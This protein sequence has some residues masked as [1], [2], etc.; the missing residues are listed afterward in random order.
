MKKYRLM[1]VILLLVTFALILWQ[2][3]S[4]TRQVE[5]DN[6][7]RSLDQ[8]LSRYTLSLK[9]EL[10]KYQNLPALLATDRS[11][12]NVLYN[13]DNRV[14]VGTLNRYLS[15]VRTITGASDIYLMAPS[16]QTLASS[17]WDTP[18]SFVG[19]NFHYRP[20]FQQ[21]MAGDEGR[22][23]ALGTTSRKRG[24]YFS[25]PIRSADAVVG[26]VVVKID[27]NDIEEQW[28][29]ELTDLL[30]TDIDDV[31]F[32]STRESWKFKTLQPLSGS[33]LR[34]IVDSLRYVDQQLVSL[35]I[36][37]RE[38]LA[39]GVELIT[40]L[41]DN[42]AAGE[43]SIDRL[44]GAR[45]MLMRLPMPEAELN[46]V[47]LAQLSQVSSRVWNAVVLTGVILTVLVLLGLFLLLRQRI[48]YERQRFK[49]QANRTLE[50][51]EARVRAVIDNTQAGLITLDSQGRIE[52]FNPTAEA[53]FGYSAGKIESRYFSHL[54][55]QPDRAVCWRMIT[56]PQELPEQAQVPVLEVQA[57][58]QDD[59]LFPIEL[60][61]VPV[62]DHGER[63]FIVTIHD[64]TERKQYEESLRDA[65]DLLE[66]R[67]L[68]RTQ[69]LQG[70][71]DRLRNEIEQHQHTQEELIQT[72]KLAVLGELSAGIN[73]ELNQ[74][75]TAI[76]AYA[77][78]ARQFLELQRTDRVADNLQEISGLTERMSKIIAPLKVF[79]RKS[80]GQAEPVSLLS[81]RKGA[82][83]I[84]YGRLHS[85][86]V[87][88]NWPESLEDLLVM[89]D[90]VKLEQVVVNLLS[91]AVQA[92]QGQ[93]NKRIDI[94]LEL[95]EE[96]L[97]LVF[98]DQ[99]PGIAPEELSKVFEPF[100]T[101]KAAGEGLGLG[102][103]ISHRIVE[104]LGGRLSASNHPQGGACFRLCLLRADRPRFD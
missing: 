54:I 53:L 11:F 28:N 22:Y 82:M 43:R 100:F 15:E 61:I 47:A 37:E 39:E 72:A 14:L 20:Y 101:T 94:G 12:K 77:D 48:Q 89:G 18:A 56:D 59:A 50:L 96:H 31:I 87:E 66:Q 40:L 78:N 76:R 38:P 7:R 84:L 57:R 24:Y 19:K 88:V 41:E 32:I 65:R 85:E 42:P 52:S 36:T 102:L 17:N 51:N 62:R 10:E 64:L 6:L 46:V 93:P 27:L 68:E 44:S 25:H 67:V 2:V 90:M 91:N 73:H 26:V 95:T 3:A 23:F 35:P 21:A 104:N 99:G 79:S 55:A 33:D 49:E 34:R 16:G 92:M 83:S 13:P 71:N 74:P 69:A 30:V 60:T 86:Q 4:L 70:A 5:L 9:N 45:Y 98:H 81:V 103:S 80:S 8:N 97:C 29:D 63:K 58:R 1:A 75:M